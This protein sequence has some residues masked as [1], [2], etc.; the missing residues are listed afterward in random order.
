MAIVVDVLTVGEA[1]KELNLTSSGVRFLVLKGELP[2][3][4][5]TGLG[6]L[7]RRS[8]VKELRDWRRREPWAT[9]PG[10]LSV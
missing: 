10:W 2:V 6:R 9:R 4:Q 3:A 1:A 8:D 5:Q 7:F